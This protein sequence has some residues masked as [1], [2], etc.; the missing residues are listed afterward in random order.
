MFDYF[1]FYCFEFSKTRHFS[2]F[3]CLLQKNSNAFLVYLSFLKL[4][5]LPK[6]T[7]YSA[8]TV[9]KVVS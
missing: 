6:D 2:F 4:E 3:C 7:I 1:P 5:T 8:S 9:A